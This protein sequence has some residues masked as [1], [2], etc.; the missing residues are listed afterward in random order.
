MLR[1]ITIVLGVGFLSMLALYYLARSQ[2]EGALARELEKSLEA[3]R[4]EL[5]KH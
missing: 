5:F 3:L 1:A 2:D 4:A